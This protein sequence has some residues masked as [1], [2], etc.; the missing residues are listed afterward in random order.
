MQPDMRH[1]VKV[2][3]NVFGQ[4][5]LYTMPLT[6]GYF[7]GCLLTITSGAA[8]GQTARIVEYDYLADIDPKVN[9]PTSPMYFPS[10][11]F[12]FRV[13]AFQ[14]AD[15][16]PL[17]VD[18]DPSRNP[19][20][21]DLKGATFVVNGRAFG[22]TGVGY[23]PMAAIGTPRLSAL[24][25]FP[26]VPGTY[27]GGQIALMPNSSYLDFTKI[28]APNPLAFGSGANPFAPGGYTPMAVKPGGDN[29]YFLQINNFNVKP[30]TLQ[31]P[32]FAGQGDV[33]ESYD[34]ADFQNMFLALQTVTPRSQGRVR[35]SDFTR[36]LSVNEDA[37]FT[38]GAFVNMDKFL[39]LDLEDLPIPSFHRPDLVNYWYHQLLGVLQAPPFDLSGDEAAR[40]ILNPSDP[41]VGPA[42]AAFVTNI[43]RRIMLRP[44]REDH[45]RFDGGNPLS[46][47]TGLPTTGLVDQATKSNITIPYWEAVGPWDVDNDNDGVPD[48]IWVDLGD[49]VQQAEDGTRYKALY[50]YLIVDLDSRLNVNAHG[51]ADDIVPQMIGLTQVAPGSFQP[52]IRTLEDGLIRRTDGTINYAPQPLS[53]FAPGP[54]LA[55]GTFSSQLLPSGVGYG[56]AEISLRPLFQAP[57]DS[58]FSPTYGNRSESAGPVDSYATVLRG[59]IRLDATEVAG[60]YGFDPGP[61]IA[62]S[63]AATSGV[64]YQYAPDNPTNPT[65]DL[66]FPDLAAQLKF[67]DYPWRID[68][69]QPSVPRQTSWRNTRWA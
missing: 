15:G 55:G 40:A 66:R 50:S 54:N 44:L 16:Q 2:D 22:G 33:N 43:K 41:A 48:S 36:P 53:A 8:A 27:V 17:Q 1:I 37:V 65:A 29:E 4:T 10:R 25:L 47:P 12:R 49:P 38:N 13:M 11:I 68:Q 6:K 57:L 45:P 23:N 3:R 39:R 19:E 30:A 59:R 63:S 42:A 32:S 9:L 34:A 5:Q 69:H 26:L 67:F 24:Q 64:N 35:H 51:L 56:P 62:P 46:V 20:I 58:S 21:S 7:N 61:I 18:L 52:V 28:W 60:K 14:R 31:Y